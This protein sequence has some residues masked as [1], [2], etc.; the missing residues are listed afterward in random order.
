MKIKINEREFE[1]VLKAKEQKQLSYEQIYLGTNVNPSTV[2][3]MFRLK[4]GN[5]K[6]WDL[7]KNFIKTFEYAENQS[8]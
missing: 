4:E 7:V 6:K 2:G 3:K 1:E 5:N 8:K